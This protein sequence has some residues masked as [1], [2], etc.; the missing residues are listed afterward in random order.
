MSPAI[1]RRKQE[2]QEFKARISYASSSRPS[3]VRETLSKQNETKQKTNTYKIQTDFF[4]VL[5]R[6]GPIELQMYVME[7]AEGK[8]KENVPSLCEALGLIIHRTKHKGETEEEGL[9]LSCRP[10]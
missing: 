5:P 8:K 4:F 9:F 7:T 10:A 3:E 1:R 6:N 2:N